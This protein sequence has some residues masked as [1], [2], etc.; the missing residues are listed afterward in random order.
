MSEIDDILSTRLVISSRS[1]RLNRLT[2]TVHPLDRDYVI[3]LLVGLGWRIVSGHSL[4]LDPDRYVL[5]A[6]KE[7]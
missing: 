3:S 7:E 5:V 1:Q 4:A 2:L 6:E